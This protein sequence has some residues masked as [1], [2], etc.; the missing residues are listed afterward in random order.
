MTHKLP[1]NC[2][3]GDERVL[4]EMPCKMLHNINNHILHINLF[5]G[6]PH[7]TYDELQ[8]F[9]PNKKIDTIIFFLLI[10]LR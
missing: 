1:F 10:Q 8:F 4:F 2:I 5:L 3:N 9:F 7:M 6:L